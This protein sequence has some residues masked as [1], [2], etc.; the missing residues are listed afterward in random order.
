M[1]LDVLDA[2]VA[3]VYD[4]LD[5]N[6]RTWDERLAGL[7]TRFEQLFPEGF[8]ESRL[9]DL[10]D[11]SEEEV[12]ERIKASMGRL[13]RPGTRRFVNRLMGTKRFHRLTVAYN[14]DVALLLLGVRRFLRSSMPIAQALQ[15]AAAP[16]TPRE[17][18]DLAG[19]SEAE[20]VLLDGVLKLDQMVGSFF[21]NRDIDLKAK[22][23]PLRN[24]EAT[25]LD[26]D[27]DELTT[28]MRVMLDVET[29]HRAQEI[30]DVLSRKLRGFEQA[31]TMSDDGVSQAA[32]SLVEFID[33]LL[34]TA[35]DEDDVLEWVRKYC[36]D[37]KDLT[38]DRGGKLVPTK[39][40][41]ALCFA[42]AAQQPEE[43]STLESMVALSIVKVRGAAEKLKHASAG[44]DEE[45]AELRGLMQSLRGALTFTLRFN[46]LLANDDRYSYLQERFDKVAAA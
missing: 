12:S 17:R 2:M 7:S 18:A 29:Q 42:H 38:F 15:D 4:L 41:S 21:N 9:A 23:F 44:T 1:A 14:D 36:P 19:L 32:N 31:L 43:N 8:P 46:W 33:R 28:I 11:L 30:S 34:R 6:G 3:T 25:T 22:G 13:N 24:E 37:E 27:L 40:A 5:E 20:A 35:F 16:L 10:A 39:R 26:V 45:E